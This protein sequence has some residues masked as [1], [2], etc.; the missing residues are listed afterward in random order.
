LSQR[1]DSLLNDAAVLL[2]DAHLAFLLVHV[3]ANM[4]DGWPPLFAALCALPVVEPLATTSVGAARFIP[5]IVEVDA[6]TASCSGPKSAYP[7]GGALRI[8]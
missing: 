8:E 7:V 5:S 3:D 2:Q 1:P 4:I 6:S